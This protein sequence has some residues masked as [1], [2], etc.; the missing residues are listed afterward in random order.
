VEVCNVLSQLALKHLLSNLR[1]DEG[2]ARNK[3][4]IDSEVKDS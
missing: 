4:G 2:H 3:K 1:S